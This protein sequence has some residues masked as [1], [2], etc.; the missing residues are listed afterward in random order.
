MAPDQGPQ[1]LVSRLDPQ[2]RLIFNLLRRTQEKIL[3]FTSH[4]EFLIF[5]KLN[6]RIPSGLLL[7]PH[8]NTKSNWSSNLLHHTLLSTSCTILDIVITDTQNAV[9]N[10]TQEFLR[11]CRI[12]QYLVNTQTYS[13]ILMKLK[14]MGSKLQL[15]LHLQKQRKLQNKFHSSVL[16]NC[17]SAN[18]I[19]STTH[20][21]NNSPNIRPT[22]TNNQNT[23]HRTHCH[24]PNTRP[25][26]ARMRTSTRRFVKRS[27]HRARL[28]PISDNKC[29][30]NLSS[31][32]LNEHESS[33]LSWYEVLSHS[34]FCKPT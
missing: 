18:R 8:I 25:I 13:A 4:H 33:D 14:D 23:T 32:A 30:I 29:I 24:R 11:L 2:S 26:H 22:P 34:C 17:N 5:H 7:N 28:A 20:R 16:Y 19:A 6:N 27:K 10:H 1:L 21:P 15:E 9:H 12:L 3:R 31:H